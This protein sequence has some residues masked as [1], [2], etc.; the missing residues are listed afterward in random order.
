MPCIWMCSGYANFSFFLQKKLKTVIQEKFISQSVYYGRVIQKVEVGTDNSVTRSH[1]CHSVRQFLRK[2]H[3]F[4]Y[5]IS[6]FRGE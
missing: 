4:I 6:Q 2:V 1:Q 5:T 3:Y